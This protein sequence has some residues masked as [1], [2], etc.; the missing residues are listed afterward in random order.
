[1]LIDLRIYT[2]KPGALAQCIPIIERE[3]LPV[4]IRHCGTLLGYFTTETGTLNQVVQL[5]AYKDAA[6]RDARRAALW[7]DP[8]WTHYTN[9]VLPHIQHQENRFLRALPSYPVKV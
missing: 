4:Q 8:E 1:M 6:D 2:F 3:G 5:W 7:A 9:Q